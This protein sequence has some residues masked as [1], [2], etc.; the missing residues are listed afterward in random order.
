MAYRSNGVRRKNKAVPLPIWQELFV[1]V[2][3]V[4]LKVSPVYWG[5]GIPPGDGSAV[6]VVPG[7]MG[8]DLYLSEFRA[9]LGRIGYKPYHSKIGLNAECPNLLIRQHLMQTVESACRTTRKRVHLVGHSLGG[10]LARAV[11]S[12]MPDQVASVITMGAPFRG[13]SAH[14][15]ILQLS[16]L[17]RDQILQRHG[18]DVL[19]DC[20][21]S[22]CTCDFLESIAGTIP[23]SVRQSAIYTK[24]DGIVDWRVCRTGRPA[25][26][27]E[28]SAT[29]LGLAFNPIVYDVVARRLAAAQDDRAVPARART[30]PTTSIVQIAQIAPCRRGPRPAAAPRKRRLAA[31]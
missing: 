20:Y 3:M 4:C 30:R 28:V 24:S 14:S 22:R 19:P 12:Q 2:E 9:W 8:T 7:F 17:V 29:H 10:L 26:D 27:F 18:E 15:S 25:I 31:R 11:A 21:T 5:F 23:R 6:V 1:A 16:E 13:I